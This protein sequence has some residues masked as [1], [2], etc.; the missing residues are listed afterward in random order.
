MK[1]SSPLK[2]D[3]TNA[4][5]VRVMHRHGD[6]VE[7]YDEST[8]TYTV[9]DAAQDEAPDWLV[10]YDEVKNLKS[11]SH[12]KVDKED[13]KRI[14]LKLKSEGHSLETIQKVINGVKKKRYN[15]Y[16]AGV[17]KY[18]SILAGYGESEE[19]LLNLAYDK[20]IKRQDEKLFSTTGGTT[21]A[22]KKIIKEEMKKSRAET[23]EFGTYEVTY[24]DKD[25]NTIEQGDT[26]SYEKIIK[27]SHVWDKNQG[28][29]T[30]SLSDQ[31]L[32]YG[33]DD[34]VANTLTREYKH[35]GFTFK[36]T[37]ANTLT[38]TNSTT[39]ETFEFYTNQSVGSGEKEKIQAQRLIDWM[40]GQPQE[41]QGTAKIQ[42]T[43]EFEKRQKI[44]Q[45]LEELETLGDVD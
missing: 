32:D 39:G 7:S 23:G 43:G 12:N 1:K 42:S 19:K 24:E 44:D 38:A 5:G 15:E 36:D 21:E 13:I 29:N 22:Q 20:E 26:S 28:Y 18:N 6:D 27:T 11:P 10:T 45:K 8:G 41:I 4:S 31:I 37:G 17:K 14:Y 35:L 25:G 34:F 33:D 2:H 3:Q 30:T 16:S 9:N 40:S